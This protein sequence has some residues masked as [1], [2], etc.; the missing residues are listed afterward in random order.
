MKPAR[1]LFLTIALGISTAALTSRAALAQFG[2]DC[3]T[4]GTIARATSS[5]SKPA[6]A[7]AKPD[8]FALF[9]RLRTGATSMYS[10]IAPIARHP[11]GRTSARPRAAH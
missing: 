11:I 2:G 8:Y 6:D 1:V 3:P 7:A 10:W 4:G 5:P 9:S